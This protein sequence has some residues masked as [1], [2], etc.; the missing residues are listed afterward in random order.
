MLPRGRQ[1]RPHHSALPYSKI[2]GVLTTIRAAEANEVSKLAFE[3]LVLTASRTSEL[4]G[5][6]WEEIDR[7]QKMW[8]VPARRIKAGKEHRVFLMLLRLLWSYRPRRGR[9]RGLESGTGRTA[10]QSHLP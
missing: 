5:A 10:R 6:R 8:I 2:A 1:T 3:F 4:I 9:M 7:A